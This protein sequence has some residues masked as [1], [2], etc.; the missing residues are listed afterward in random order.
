MSKLIVPVAA[1]AEMVSTSAM[2]GV[3]SA[4]AD[5][6]PLSVSVVNVA[7]PILADLTKSEPFQAQTATSP[8]RMVTPE[9]GP[10]PRRTMLWV[11]E[12]ALMTM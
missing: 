3:V 11:L 9:V 10:T 4:V 7:A 1:V 8:L 2:L 12:L 6:V 5:D